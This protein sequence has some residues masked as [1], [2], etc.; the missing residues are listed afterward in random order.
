MQL[1]YR[2]LGGRGDPIVIL[3][4]L[5]G[6]AQNWAGMGRKLS[7]AG[8]VFTLDM[9]NHGSSPHAAPHSLEACVQDLDEWSTTTGLRGLRLIGHSM[10]GL[11]AMGFALAH[12]ERTAGVAAVDIAPRPYPP[13][14]ERELRALRTDISACA[15]RADI[16]ILLSGILPD[17]RVRQFMMTNVIRE[18]NGF[19][20]R[21]DPDILAS[22]T[23]ASDFAGQTG[24]YNGESLLVRCGRSP[25]VR[26]EDRE[27]MAR[28]F[29]TSRME[30]IPDADHWPHVTAPTALEA[31]LRAFLARVSAASPMQ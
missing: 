30:T 14:H 11:V 21:L 15:S 20:W 22:S 8:R 26:A 2:D 5:F 18:D 10:G 24:C 28:Y 4:G 7:A 13:D 6:A 23:V 29:P 17:Q 3:H 19:R 25:Y 9:R 1:A 31:I 12:P 16:D 27:V